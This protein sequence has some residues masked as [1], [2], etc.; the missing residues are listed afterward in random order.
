MIARFPPLGMV[1]AFALVIAGCNIVTPL[2]YVVTPEPTV[3]AQFELA[4]RPTVV[5]IDDRRNVVSPSSLRRVIADR[6]TE[7]LIKEGVLTPETAIRPRDALGVAMARDKSGDLLPIDEIG[8]AVGAEQIIYVEMYA[9]TG[10]V[11]GVKPQPGAAFQV[12]VLDIENRER[13]FPVPEPDG[14]ESL[15]VK[16]YGRTMSPELYQS[17]SSRIQIFET[18]ALRVGQ[19]VAQVFYDHRPED[20]LGSRLEAP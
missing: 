9:F 2:A 7:L 8:R 20:V 18:L 5:F 3:E 4:N 15:P 6:A 17:R 11:D 13:L 12:K 14:P 10:T 16:S 1:V 19:D